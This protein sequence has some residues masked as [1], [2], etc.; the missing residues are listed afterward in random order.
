VRSFPKVI[1]VMAASACALAATHLPISLTGPLPAHTGGFG[2]PS[3]HACHFDY[4]VNEGDV[5]VT[6]D[7]L[8]A[9]FEPE[10]SYRLQLRVQHPELK[11]GGFQLSA[12]FDDG[13]PAGSF[14]IPDT[15]LLRVQRAKSVDYLSHTM[16][17]SDQLVG[18]TAVWNF[19]WVAPAAS[20]RVVFNLAVNVADQDASQFG[21]RIYT[22]VFYSG[23][24][25][26]NK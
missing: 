11:R 10:R 15:S 16:K 19:E 26:I 8:P 1:I 25:P 17:G 12:R 2:E 14:V 7:S 20:R 22:R 5:R 23:G 18:D 6:F 9:N 21:D 3:C 24:E 13:T 4:V